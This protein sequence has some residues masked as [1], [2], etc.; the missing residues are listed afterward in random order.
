MFAVVVVVFVAAVALLLLTMISHLLFIQP[1][2]RKELQAECLSYNLNA[3]GKNADLKR[4]LTKYHQ[5]MA[6]GLRKLKEKKDKEAAEAKAKEA[7]E[8]AAK[9]AAA[10]EAAA[11]EAAAKQKSTGPCADGN[12]DE[13]PDIE[14]A[15][16]KTVNG[17]LVETVTEEDS[18]FEDFP[19]K[20]NLEDAVEMFSTKVK[21]ALGSRN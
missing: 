8:A 10:K 4:R 7:E 16:S 2:T 17:V 13:A 11:K 15:K 6:A 1:K 3:G 14:G 19:A 5:K 21:A 9:E 18:D 20:P 12:L